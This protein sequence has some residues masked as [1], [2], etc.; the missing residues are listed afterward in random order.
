MLLSCTDR[1]IYSMPSSYTGHEDQMETHPHLLV[2]VLGGMLAALA[3]PPQFLQLG[4]AL[5][6]TLPFALVL[7]LVLL[8][9]SLRGAAQSQPEQTTEKSSF[10][11]MSE[12]L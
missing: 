9:C 8:Q 3:L 6:Q 12:A 4:L 7:H 1:T 2:S 5:L 10:K 11:R